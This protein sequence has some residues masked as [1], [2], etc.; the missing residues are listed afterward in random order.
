MNKFLFKL[1]NYILFYIQK[2][3][4]VVES[5]TL[6]AGYFL[7]ANIYHINMFKSIWYYNLLK[8][9]FAPPDWIFSP[10]WSILYCTIVIALLLYIFKPAE[11]K[12]SGYIYFATQLILNC[13][14]TPAFFY[15][16]NI[17]LALIIIILLDI[18]VLLTI[19]SFYKVSKFAS[20]IL[21]P[22]LIWILFATY[23][24]IGY[25]ILNGY[26]F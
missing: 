21:I 17:L 13:L 3:Y 24:N 5:F 2:N 14:W 8:P 10:V 4:I 11:N 9:P 20:L 1:S 7:C 23:L 19:Y 16:Q 18:F 25:L 6:F 15:L 26:N 12:K 22:Y